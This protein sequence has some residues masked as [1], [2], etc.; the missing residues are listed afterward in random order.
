MQIDNVYIAVIVV[1][2]ILLFSPQIG[3]LLS[4]LRNTLTYTVSGRKPVRNMRRPVL[5]LPD[6]DAREH[7]VD[8]QGEVK[9][10]DTTQPNASDSLQAL[11]YEGSLPWDQAIQAT[12]LDPATFSNHQEYVADVRRF[13]SGANFTSVTDD[14]TSPTF[15][16]FVGLRRPEHVDVGDD[17]RQVPSEDPTVLQRNKVFRWNS[18]S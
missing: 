17:A 15:S 16:N 5:L 3:Y 2:L 1:L 9:S 7:L 10:Y 13:S 18:T 4:C 14:N 11:G 12:E 6:D 8:D